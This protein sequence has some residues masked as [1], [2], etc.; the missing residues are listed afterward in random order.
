MTSAHQTPTPQSTAVP[1]WLA[2]PT[3]TD[4]APVW[5]TAVAPSVGRAPAMWLLG[6]HG[7]AG[8]STLEAMWAPA[9]SSRRGWPAAD[10][11]PFVVVVARMHAA[12]LDAAHQLCLQHQAGQ[13]GGCALLGLVTVAAAPGKPAVSLTRRRELVAAAAGT[14]WHIDWVPELLTATASELAQWQP[15]YTAPAVK[16]LAKPPHPTEVVPASAVAAAEDIFSA[17]GQQWRQRSQT[18]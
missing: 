2:V 14:S 12:G 18:P 13:V 4:R 5:D 7:G 15:G 1:K 16:R 8:V 6:A 9:A 10:A 17:A 3:E 11:A